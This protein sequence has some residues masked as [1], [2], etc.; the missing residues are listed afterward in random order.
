MRCTRSTSASAMLSCTIRRRSDVQ[1]WPA[2]PTAAKVTARAAISRSALGATIMALLPP[3]S[4]MARP[5]RS[6][7][8]TATLRPMRVLPVALT[9]ATCRDAARASPTSRPPS[10]TACSPAGAVCGCVAENCAMARASRAWHA[11]AVNG[12][13]SDGFQRTLSPQTRA[14]AVFHDHTATGKLKAEMT[15]T[16]PAGCQVSIIRCPGRSEAMV[17]P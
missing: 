6:A 3:S 12:V 10:S 7:T 8:C 5:K 16:T 2:V 9:T 13:F 15:P 14:S 17:R 11:S 1:R 4:R